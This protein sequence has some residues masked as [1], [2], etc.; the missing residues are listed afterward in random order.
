MLTKTE[1]K[2]L[3]ELAAHPGMVMHYWA[4]THIPPY[5]NRKNVILGVHRIRRKRPDVR[6]ETVRGTGYVYDAT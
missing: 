3:D 6:I 5:D 4:F 2:L 1:Q